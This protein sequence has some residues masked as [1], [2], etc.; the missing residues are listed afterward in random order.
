MNSIIYIGMDV[1]SSNYTLCAFTLDS[2]R[3]FA[4]TQIKP[5]IKLLLNYFE[6][7]RKGCD[8]DAKIICGYEAGG[9]GYSLYKEIIAH[10]IECHILAPTT[11][12]VSASAKEKK[13]DKRDARNIV[14]CLAFNTYNEVFVPS[15]EDNSVKEYIR[16]RDDFRQMLKQTKQQICALCLR[17]GKQYDA[18][19]HKWTAA[20]RQW[21][22]KL[23]FEHPLL[24]ETLDEYMDTLQSLE[25]KAKR[26][27]E[28][29]LELSNT[30]RYREN[31]KK[32]CC[33]RGIAEHTALA[34][35]AETG[36]FYR[37]PTAAHYA[38]YLGLTPGEHSSGN[39]KIITGITKAG[40]GHLRRLLIESSQCYGR[41]N[42][43]I[44][45]AVLKRKQKGCTS[46]IVRYSDR[47][48]IRLCK[49]FNRI[50]ERSHFNVAK[51]AI[52]RELAC[53]IWGMMTGRID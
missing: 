31:V 42:P 20:H 35:L 23:E 43:K 3:F 45:S 44:K 49:K 5:D 18:T 39:S 11:M 28:R 6:T 26:L 29:I 30:D 41:G 47:A 33:F 25:E 10:D 21:L 1:H 14:R 9:L 22:K 53:F 48:S 8:L 24:R 17:C 40:N 15:E 12:A 38:S 32:L 46:E 34:L 52:A 27:D 50:K 7:V 36:D 13:T 4:E 16:M 51:T 2:N 19:K 37:F